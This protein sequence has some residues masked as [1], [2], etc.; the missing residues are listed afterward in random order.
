MHKT[1]GEQLAEWSGPVR[2]GP[3]HTEQRTERHPT[4]RESLRGRLQL[5]SSLMEARVRKLELEEAVASIDTQLATR[6]NSDD[7]WRYRAQTARDSF[8]SDMRRV[9]LCLDIFEA[10]EAGG[11][12]TLERDRAV[13]AARRLAGEVERLSVELSAAVSLHAT[14]PVDRAFV[15][16]AR[17]VL[18]EVTFQRIMERAKD[19]NK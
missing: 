16:T 18:S 5:P 12:T 4:G 2:P 19:R 9:Q 17:L 1:M 6:A 7:T 11:V 15:E 10:R 13:D 3:A 14:A 8:L